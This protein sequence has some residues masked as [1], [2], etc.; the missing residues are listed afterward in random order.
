MAKSLQSNSERQDRIRATLSFVVDTG[1]KPVNYP[2]EAGGR[3]ERDVGVEDCHEIEIKNARLASPGCQIDRQ[4][5][6]L[7]EQPRPEMDLYDDEVV[8]KRYKPSVEALLKT[9]L[10]ARRVFV[11][12]HTRR[13]DDNAVRD[14]RKIRGPAALVH[15]D[16]TP[17]S[18]VQRLK[19][20][21]PD[22][23]G[24]IKNGRLQIVN[25][26]RSLE[27]SVERSPLAMCD[28]RTVAPEDAIAT[29][30]RARDRIGEIYRFAHNPAHQWY[31]YPSL[32]PDEAILIRTFDS[33]SDNPM[34]CAPHCAIDDPNTAADAPPRCSIELRAFVL[35]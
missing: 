28:A 35:H 2:S 24:E 32:T 34:Q 27:G 6:E 20:Y 30:R 21:L 26:W 22:E 1:E 12:D 15:N 9:H 33:A 25:I 16:Y 8:D 19:D 14:A 31:Y 29:E 4:G 11:F 3:E 7:I 18:G 23:A 5:F 17:W 10:Q 13:T